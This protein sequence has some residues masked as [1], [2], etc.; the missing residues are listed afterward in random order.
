MGLNFLMFAAFVW[1]IWQGTSM[2]ALYCKRNRII[3]ALF[4]AVHI[5]LT[6]W[7]IIHNRILHPYADD[8]TGLSRFM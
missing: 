3:I 8:A 2:E 4:A 1:M 7:S 6:I 5:S